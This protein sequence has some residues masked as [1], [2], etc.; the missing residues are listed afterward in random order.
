[1]ARD[2]ADTW[3]VSYHVYMSFSPPSRVTLAR[4]TGVRELRARIES[5]DGSRPDAGKPNAGPRRQCT[6]EAREA[7]RRWGASQLKTTVNAGL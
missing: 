5:Q 3:L 4:L 1:M 6:E 7:R 2:S